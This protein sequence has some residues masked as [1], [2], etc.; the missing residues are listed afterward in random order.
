MRERRRA[1]VV[2]GRDA[3]ELAERKRPPV[4]LQRRVECEQRGRDVGGMR[5][6]A[7]VVREDRVLAML[8]REREADVAAVQPAW[9][10]EPPV[11]AAGRL[12]Q[13]PGQGARVPELRAGGQPAGFA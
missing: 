9:V 2:L 12:E 13:V 10:L 5:R 4:G 3:V 6:G 7:V 1:A 8:A 11:P